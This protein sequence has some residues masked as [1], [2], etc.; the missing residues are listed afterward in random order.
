MVDGGKFISGATTALSVMANLEVPH[1]N[2]LSKVDLL[3]PSA[4]RQLDTFLHPDTRELTERARGDAS[5]AS[6][7]RA[8]LTRALARVLDD[9]SLVK[10][11]PLD[12]R[13]EENVQDL[14]QAVDNCI[15]YGEDLE[16]RTESLE[17]VNEAGAD[18]DPAQDQVFG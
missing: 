5:F 18:E 10:F 6:E 9:Y 7:R 14:L 3:P 13:D 16:V 1:V 11:F 12:P 4:R 2:V 15:Q 8:R 17:N